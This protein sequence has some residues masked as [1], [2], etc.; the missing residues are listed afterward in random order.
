MNQANLR[1]S[2]LQLVFGVAVVAL[3]G[4]RAQEVASAENNQSESTIQVW[5]TG[6]GV[7]V[8]PESGRYFEDRRDVHADYPGGDYRSRNTVWDA[9]K[10]RATLHAAR[11]ELVAFQVVVESQGPAKDTRVELDRLRGPNGATISGRHVALSK[12]WYVPVEQVSSGYEK[13]SLGPGWYPDAL[14]PAAD[15]HTLSLEIPDANNAVG[16]GQR[17]QSV[18]VDVYVPRDRAKAARQKRSG[19]AGQARPLGARS[20]PGGPP[21]REST[22][23]TPLVDMSADDLVWLRDDLASDGTHPSQSGRAKVAAQLLQFFKTDPTAK[24]WFVGED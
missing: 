7:R 10:R 18:W 2:A 4:V 22:G 6:D 24:P 14:V 20:R 23:L 16:P 3:G 19:R 12:A 15:G 21:A 11:N 17:N 5:A 1:L 13:L 9:A 8:N